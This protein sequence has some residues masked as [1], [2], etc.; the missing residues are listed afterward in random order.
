[1]LLMINNVLAA[2]SPFGIMAAFDATTLT[3]ISAP[4]KAAK[5]AWA[6]ERFRDLGAKWSRGAGEHILWDINEPVIGGGYDWSVPDAALLKAYQNGGNGF[7]MVVVVTPQRG[8]GAPGDIPSANETD[9]KNFVKALVERYKG[10]GV[11]NYDPAIKVKYWQA[12]NEPFPAQWIVNGGTIEGYIRFVELFSQAAREADPDAKIV[13]G[14]F[15]LLTAG[16]VAKFNTVV[17]ALKNKNLFDYADTHFWGEGNNYK[18]PL[19]EARSILD[20]NGYSYVKIMSLEYGTVVG[21]NGETE[22]DQAK[23]LIKGYAYN[24]ANGFSLINWNNLV[25]WS[26]F[27]LPGGIYNYMG[28]VADGLN[29][30]PVPAGTRRLSYY[31]YKK[32]VE[33][34]EGSDCNNIQA[35][36]ES[37]GVYIYR[38]TKSSKSI[39]VAWNDNA[40]SR[41]IEISGIPSSQVKITKAIPKYAAGIEV[42]DYNNAFE[43]ET[44]TVT[45]AEISVII[46]DNPVFIE[47]SASNSLS[48]ARI[49]T[50]PNPFT[51]GNNRKVKIAGLTNGAMIQIY[52][53]S[54]EKINEVV[55]DSGG[56]AAWDGT[57][58][59]GNL[60]ARGMYVGLISDSSGNKRTVKIAVLK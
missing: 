33:I 25:E 54:G 27:D 58:S 18:I 34:L 51:M 9:F 37:D 35:V 60:A 20:S 31:T 43:T 56:F 30:D 5:T 16:Y 2:D 28:L 29:G 57:N 45:D 52:T 39:W 15:D 44:K 10:D 14:T 42:I 4:D 11:H 24:L 55:A 38:F 8:H 40:D 23:W 19:G 49:Y 41:Q 26:S 53:I 7:N 3:N 32:M 1:M 46:G 36:K 12:D 59:S 22:K 48:N 6:G 47:Y 50:Y 21:R 17:S 13:L